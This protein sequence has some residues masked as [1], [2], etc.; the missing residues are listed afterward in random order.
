MASS[1][2][3]FRLPDPPKAHVDADLGVGSLTAAVSA[4]AQNQQ[5]IEQTEAQLQVT[6]PW[7]REGGGS[8][9]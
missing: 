7:G 2:L 8:G 6:G 1:G 4:I 3:S 5:K 9:G